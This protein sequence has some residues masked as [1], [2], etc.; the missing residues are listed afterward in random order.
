MPLYDYRCSNGEVFEAFY[1][2]REK[3]DTMPCPHCGQP[4]TSVP[5][6]IGPSKLNSTQMRMIDAT[7]ET[8]ETPQVVNSISGSRTAKR[9]PT[10]YTTHP[11]HQKLPRP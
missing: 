10:R 7:K 6:A 8:A 2:M 4:A 9:Q 5:P 11:L 3:P 1:T